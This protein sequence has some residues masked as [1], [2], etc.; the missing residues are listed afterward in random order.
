M[1]TAELYESVR[2]D[3]VQGKGIPRAFM[4][5]VTKHKHEAIRLSVYFCDRFLEVDGEPFTLELD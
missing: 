2:Q 1:E 3:F 5:K 4:L